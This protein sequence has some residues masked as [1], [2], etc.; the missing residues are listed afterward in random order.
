M[1]PARLDVSEVIQGESHRDFV[2]AVR[3]RHGLQLVT[4]W[5]AM[6]GALAREPLRRRGRLPSCHRYARQ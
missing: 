5:G 4:G 3:S 6:T 1:W 2:A